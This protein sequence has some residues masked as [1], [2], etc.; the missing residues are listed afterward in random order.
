MLICLACAAPLGGPIVDPQHR[1]PQC[2]V[3][4]P[5]HFGI[6]DLRRGRYEFAD[7]V[8]DPEEDL[9]EA[10]ALE[11]SLAIM[12]YRDWFFSGVDEMIAKIAHPQRRR[13]AADY[14]RT[15]REVFGIHGEA[16]LTKLRAFLADR[17]PLKLVRWSP[18]TGAALE[19]GCGSGQYPIAFARHFR[20]VYVTDLSYVALVQARKI[21]ADEALGNVTFFASTVEA[22]PLETGSIEFVHSNGVIEHVRDPERVVSESARVLSSTGV[23]F[24][25]SPS[26]HS[27]Y[28]EPHFRVVG[29]SFWPLPLRRVLARR[30]RGKDSFA[31]LRLRSL[32]EL[33]AWGSR[34]FARHHLYMVPRRLTSTARGGPARRLIK[35]L[36]AVPVVGAITDLLINR[37]LLAVMPYHIMVG[38]ASDGRD[39]SAR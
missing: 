24:F 5:V 27:L 16:V 21:A 6:I 9:A 4:Y 19:A 39:S 13:I 20:H 28:V 29:L 31:G 36:L 35:T 38:F 25:L 3:T 2:G 11:R 8:L 22:L 15:E 34:H 32:R 17:E 10:T 7:D 37:V 12:S 30:Y 33:R 26:K 18:T 14:Y 23:A 1:C